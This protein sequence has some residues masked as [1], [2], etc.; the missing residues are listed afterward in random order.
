MSFVGEFLALNAPW[1]SRW[2]SD[3]IL[4]TFSS[5]FQSS[6]IKKIPGC[7]CQAPTSSL[8]YW[9]KFCVQHMRFASILRGLPA[10]R[11]NCR[12]LSRSLSLKPP[13]WIFWRTQYWT[14][15]CV[16]PKEERGWISSRQTSQPSK[17]LEPNL[18][19][20]PLLKRILYRATIRTGSAIIT[21]Y[22]R[23]CLPKTDKPMH[24]NSPNSGLS[25][26]TV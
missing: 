15:Q 18:R 7:S 1:T 16:D 21:L 3:C 20:L 24:L 19:I 12:P 6:R 11:T 13:N 23:D 14:W 26:P 4:A 2:R 22:L 17:R 8:R 9:T 10:R 5:R 25:L